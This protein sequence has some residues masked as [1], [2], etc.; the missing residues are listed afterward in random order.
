MFV[1]TGILKNSSFKGTS[2]KFEGAAMEFFLLI[3]GKE[4]E[5]LVLEKQILQDQSEL[6]LEFSSVQARIKS[7]PVHLKGEEM[8]RLLIL[9]SATSTTIESSR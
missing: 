1:Q 9:P 3:D 5:D 2:G 8:R 7:V 6:R 4:A